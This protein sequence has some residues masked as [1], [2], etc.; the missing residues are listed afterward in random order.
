MATKFAPTINRPRNKFRMPHEVGTTFDGGL[1]IPLEWQEILP[2]D[3]LAKK[4]SY[5]VR[6]LT[7]INP[8]MDNA[9]LNVSAY[10]VPYEIIWNQFK[11]FMGQNE[12][13]AWSES[14]TYLIPALYSSVPGKACDVGTIGDYLGLPTGSVI[15]GETRISVL[16]LRGYLS[17][18]NYWYRNQNVC[19]PILFTK[20][21]A[22]YVSA[23]YGRG[24]ND[25]PLPSM[26]LADYFTT[27]LPEPSKIASVNL[28][29]DLPVDS[30]GETHSISANTQWN[31][32]GL[33]GVK[34][35]G[36]LGSL[37]YNQN[38]L[39]F[40]SLPSGVDDEDDSGYAKVNN[41][42]ASGTL[43]IEKFRRAAVY[44]HIGEIL[45]RGGSRYASEFL[46][47]IF[48]VKNSESLYDEPEFLGSI[49][50]LIN[51]TEVL[52]NS[53]TLSSTG[54][55]GRL[56]GSNGAMSKTTGS[57]YLF[58]HTFTRHG[59]VFVLATVRH[60]ETYF[61][62][63]EKKWTRSSFFDFYLPQAQGLGYQKV[64]K[65]EIY[66]TDTSSGG[67][68]AKQVFG[69]QDY[70]AEYR[71][72][73]NRLTGYLKPNVTGALATWTYGQILAAAPTLNPS[74]MYADKSGFDRTIA[75]DSTSY[76]DMQFF[77]NFLFDD[78]WIRVVGVQ[79]FPGLD[80]I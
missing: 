79:R 60:R 47:N 6:M 36:I 80:V 16:P 63:I 67:V 73:P 28:I 70:G 32:V 8:V 78:E 57:E 24:Y 65:Q 58:E 4:L 54:E 51:M 34:E 27:C 46:V 42:W 55:T 49:D 44:Q 40:I 39:Q 31:L 2:G 15:P 48:G 22:D 10:F 29:G 26:K 9:Y 38:K 64:L 59:M 37:N 1:V 14:T 11:Q 76:S 30:K 23:S 5:V 61:Q 20:E 71:F 35:Q 53:D 3:H 45:A 13:S 77:G 75:V 7:P 56:L 25:A 66:C 41:L 74:F 43:D 17:I 50:K 72:Q 62:G 68:N 18:W 19:D 21:S 52:S 12:T 69:Y 33:D